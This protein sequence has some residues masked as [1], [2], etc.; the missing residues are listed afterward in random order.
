VRRRLTYSILAAILCV[1]L[2]APAAP[3]SF[4][5]AGMP[6]IDHRTVWGAGRSGFEKVLACEQPGR[7]SNSCMLAAMKNGGASSQA[8]GFARWMSVSRNGFAYATDFKGPRYGRVASLNVFYPGR[9]N[10]NGAAYFVNGRPRLIDPEGELVNESAALTANPTFQR[11]RASH[12]Q[13]VPWDSPYLQGEARRPHGGQRFIVILPLVDGCHA[14]EVL[15]AT[16][17]GFDFDTE[18]SFQGTL[19]LAVE[20]GKMAWLRTQLSAAT[21]ARM[22]KA[23]ASSPAVPTGVRLDGLGTLRVGMSINEMRTS[24]IQVGGGFRGA[25]TSLTGKGCEF[26][27]LIARPKVAMMFADG[28]VARIDIISPGIS[29]DRGVSVGDTF[30][31]VMKAYHTAKVTQNIYLRDAKDVEYGPSGP[32]GHYAVIFIVDRGRVSSYR[33]GRLPEVG[34]PEDC[35]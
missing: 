2:Y 4:S 33:S 12:P 25:Q 8:V 3:Q 19:V 31:R 23:A 5:S 6:Q 10:T 17:I 27:H 20:A 34:Y 16:K 15:G 11:I 14:C 21:I 24:G 18:G 13:A 1:S 9:A 26:G 22:S 35:G 32:G 29:T 30:G 28:Y 7:N